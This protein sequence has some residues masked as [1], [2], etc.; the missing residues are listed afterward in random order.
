MRSSFTSSS[1][2][3]VELAVFECEQSPSKI[4]I[5][6]YCKVCV[7]YGPILIFKKTGLYKT[8]KKCIEVT[9]DIKM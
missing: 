8:I 5:L 6:I 2:Q 4:F 1:F 7:P 3:K 9:L